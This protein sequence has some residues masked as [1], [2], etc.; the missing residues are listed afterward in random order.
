MS[1]IGKKAII[2]HYPY[3]TDELEVEIIDKISIQKP[4]HGIRGEV[5]SWAESTAYLVADKD[6]NVSTIEPKMIV[7]IIS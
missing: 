1:L 7:K 3:N 4:G 2:N 6:G 5:I